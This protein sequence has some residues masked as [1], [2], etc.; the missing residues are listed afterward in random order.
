MSGSLCKCIKAKEG[1]CL[2]L[3]CHSPFYFFDIRSFRNVFIFYFLC[4]GVLPAC[5]S[6]WGFP[7][8]ELQTVVSYWV[9]GFELGSSR[10]VVSA[11]NCWVISPVPIDHFWYKVGGGNSHICTYTFKQFQQCFEKYFPFIIALAGYSGTHF[12]DQ[13]GLKLKRNPSVFASWVLGLKS[14]TTTTWLWKH[15]L[16]FPLSRLGSGDA[17][18]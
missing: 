8:L 7:I 18:L 17:C 15:S 10:R 3:L 11:F 4:I 13:A 12:V 9:L 16:N 14:C 2:S 1:H 6:G 5:M